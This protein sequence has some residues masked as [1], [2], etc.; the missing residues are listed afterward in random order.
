MWQGLT[1]EKKIAL[2]SWDKLCKPKEKGGLGLRDPV[3]MNKVLS[4]KIWWRWLKNPKELWARIWRKKYAPNMAD[5]SL[6]RWDGDNL[7]SLIWT[8]AKKNRQMVTQHAFWEIGNGK[9]TL[10]WKDS[11]QQWLALSAK[12]WAR[13]IC[14]QATRIGL[15]RVADYW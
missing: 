10:F 13:D 14:T 3:I 2:V 15:T 6:I 5:K 11:W 1:K 12:D 7:G 8:T 4:A 9:T